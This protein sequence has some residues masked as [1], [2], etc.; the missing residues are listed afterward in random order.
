M[1]NFLTKNSKARPDRPDEVRLAETVTGG[2]YPKRKTII[3][4]YYSVPEC[5]ESKV[6]LGN[7]TAR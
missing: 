2:N 7:V 4:G 1:D 3:Y 6:C 5:V